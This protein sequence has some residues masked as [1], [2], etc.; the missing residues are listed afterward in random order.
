VRALPLTF[1]PRVPPPPGLYAP[2]RTG[3]CQAKA[4][5]TFARSEARTYALQRSTC[6]RLLLNRGFSSLAQSRSFSPVTDTLRFPLPPSCAPPAAVS[7]FHH[8]A[9]PP[10][11]DLIVLHF[12]PLSL[13]LFCKPRSIPLTFCPPLPPQAHPSQH[14]ISPLRAAI[15]L[16]NAKSQSSYAPRFLMHLCVSLIISADHSL[17]QLILFLR[18]R[19]YD[20]KLYPLIQLIMSWTARNPRRPFAYA[21][22]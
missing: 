5:R 3:D 2:L 9:K 20:S 1:F 4:S 8:N 12:F 11:F 10:D 21:S 6:V 22:R 17:L 15:A 18:A 16:G 7:Y 19:P 14:S 13:S